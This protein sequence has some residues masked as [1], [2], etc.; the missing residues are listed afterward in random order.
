MSGETDISSKL[1]R[2]C[3]T[4]D[5][6][7]ISEE[8]YAMRDRWVP[9]MPVEDI[10]HR[11]V[12]PAIFVLQQIVDP[13]FRGRDGGVIQLSEFALSALRESLRR[14][15]TLVAR[16]FGSILAPRTLI[17]FDQH[18]ISLR[19]PEY[20]GNV[21]VWDPETGMRVC[22]P[23]PMVSDRSKRQFEI[24]SDLVF[25]YGFVG[26]ETVEGAEQAAAL[27]HLLDVT[28]SWAFLLGTRG[29][30]PEYGRSGRMF[31]RPTVTG[32]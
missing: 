13:S 8:M 28:E 18:L 27:E 19:N 26:S 24:L 20:P 3:G 21:A 17:S 10:L 9:P 12:R 25:L 14:I 2:V 23:E 11:V 15:L 16:F 31:R 6:L 1:L 22:P 32:W 5:T 29:E 7:S 30:F 4:V